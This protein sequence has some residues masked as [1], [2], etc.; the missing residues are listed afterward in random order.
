MGT[1]GTGSFFIDAN[2]V[3]VGNYASGLSTGLI[4]G[5]GGGFVES[6]T[7]FGVGNGFNSTGILTL[8]GAAGPVEVTR[9]N[10]SLPSDYA[11]IAVGRNNG[12]GSVTIQNG[13]RLTSVN[14]SFYDP[15]FYGPGDG[16]TVGGYGN[17]RVGQEGGTGTIT[18]TGD[19]SFL[20]AYGSAARMTIGRSLGEGTLNILD[21]ASAGA[22]NVV[23]GRE[24]T[25]SITVD[26]TGSHLM[27]NDSFGQF[28][29]YRGEDNS[30]EGARLELGRDGAG[31]GSLSV[32]NGGTVTVMNT[33]GVTE[34]SLIRLGR[35]SGDVGELT[36]SGAGSSVNII[37]N[38]LVSEGN[39]DA[40]WIGIGRSGQGLAVVENGGELNIIGDQNMLRL[41]QAFDGNPVTSAESRLDIRSGGKV[42]LDSGNAETYGAIIARTE[43]SNAT[44]R[45]DGSGSELLV[46][47]DT[48]DINDDGAFLQV[49]REGNGRLEI[50]N[51][52]RVLVD[53][54]TD[55]T[56]FGGSFVNVGRS[57]GSSGHIQVDGTGSSLE[58]VSDVG[59]IV[60]QGAFLTVGDRGDGSMDVTNGAQVTIDGNGDEFP[61]F[62]VGRGENDGSE[63]VLGIVT[64]DGPGSA[65][66]ISGTNTDFLGAGGFIGVGRL[67]NAE[68]RLHITNG[69]TVSNTGTASAS[70]VAGESGSRGEILIDGSGSSMDAGALLT[71]GTTFD[72]LSGTPIAGFHGDG[73]VTLRNGGVMTAD[74]TF[75]SRTGTLDLDA[76]LVSDVTT[77]G[78]L[79]MA[80]QGVG[81]ATVTGD[82]TTLLGASFAYQI[83]DFTGGTGDTLAISGAGNIDTRRATWEIEIARGVV[84][85]TGDTYTLA[86]AAGGL[87]A[88]TATTYDLTTG[89]ELEISQVGT[90]LVLEAIE[91]NEDTVGDAA[92]NTLTGTARADD[93]FGKAGN[94]TLNGLGGDDI[95][96]GG[97][98]VDTLNGGAGIDRAEYG[99]AG[100]AVRADL[101]AP[102]VNTGDASGDSY[103]SIE[104]L[105]GSAFDDELRGDNA[106]NLLQGEA[107]DDRLIGRDGDDVIRGGDGHDVL[108]GGTGADV[109]DG[110]DGIDRVQYSDAAPG[111]RVDLQYE[112]FN[113]GIAAGDLFRSIENIV[114]TSGDDDLRGN[115]SA[116]RL[117]A[118]NGD[119]FLH[120]RDGDDTLV[121]GAGDDVLLGGR[122]GDT[123]FG[124]AGTDRAS[125]SDATSSVRADLQSGAF[126]NG[127]FASGDSYSQIENLQGTD[128]DD[129]L[130]GNGLDNL[131][132][133]TE[134]DDFLTGRNGDDM[135]LGGVGDDV[136]RGGNGADVLSGSSGIDQADYVAAI[137]GVRADLQVSANNNGIAT[138]DTYIG[139]ENLRGGVGDDDLRGDGGANELLGQGGD[140]VLTGRA[141]NDVLRGIAGDDTL[142]G[143]L[144]ADLLAGSAGAD[145]F[146]F[147]D[148]N[149]GGDTILD[150]QVGID[151]IHLNNAGFTSL[152]NGALAAANFR[153]GAAALDADDFILYD[154]GTGV[155][156]YD[157]DANG[158]GAAVVIATLQ[159][160]ANIDESDFLI[161]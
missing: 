35:D 89:I 42:T 59:S 144:G 16:T 65:I 57:A 2:N 50:V 140:D 80:G 14:T 3:F 106:D 84:V 32:V 82:F 74:E 45:V 153:S 130:R 27:L 6:V 108:F 97:S 91:G 154:I 87:T 41:G 126:N 113:N 36:I 66:I 128:F 78:R 9:E 112:Q 99:D 111:I 94:D 43:G 30:R 73:V 53:S 67:E 133:G 124:G 62:Q 86:V 15:N 26:G 1:S 85:R 23:V 127:D 142:V 25:G 69:G 38:G 18:V 33:E 19:D 60:N 64:V 83:T 114:A 92:A 7:G 46:L 129:D 122:G 136:L 143:G 24:G 157:A 12:T 71:V 13:A 117:D 54:G 22:L 105:S 93:L 98:G 120:G 161:L 125:Y 134:G 104:G 51:G 75:V 39:D 152:A 119:D 90:S 158:G 115:A 37:Q 156:R 121:A 5:T 44:V 107:G 8:D 148:P 48:V 150:M 76:T 70:R 81:T 49:G 116:N 11:T 77:E 21:G 52:G 17:F 149:E 20:G 101:L 28:G 103:V 47:S 146:R 63:N 58:L 139:V 123:L 147:N 61:G 109:L 4:D 135:L 155:L 88:D 100:A 40:T 55:A 132:I 72:E 10:P 31:E 151:S 159:N 110:G 138:G 68:G 131:L 96:T 79:E 141:G 56:S 95:L 102:G 118:G 137:S 160:N 34:G 145:R 29:Q